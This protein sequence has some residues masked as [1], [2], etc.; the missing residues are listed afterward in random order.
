M[1][2]RG[3]RL[4]TLLTASACLLLS[5]LSLRLRWPHYISWALL[6]AGLATVSLDIWAVMAAG[7]GP[8]GKRD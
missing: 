5:I 4:A 8:P 6:G 7:H 1:S 3:K 2:K